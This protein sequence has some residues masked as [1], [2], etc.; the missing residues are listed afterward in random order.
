MEILAYGAIGAIVFVVVV[1]TTA[2]ISSIAYYR[3][4]AEYERE[5]F[6]NMINRRKS[7][8]EGN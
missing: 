1:Y 2:R 7:N 3:S 4:K 8:V 6:L 5:L